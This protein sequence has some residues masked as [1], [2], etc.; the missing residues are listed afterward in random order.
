MPVDQNTY[1]LSMEVNLLC[2]K[3]IA[4]I[5]GITK[6]LHDVE[7]QV[8]KIGLAFTKSMEDQTTVLQ[9]SYGDTLSSMIGD[10]DAGIEMKIPTGDLAQQV[11]LMAGA[12]KLAR[13]REDAEIAVAAV[14]GQIHGLTKR[15]V[16][17]MEKEQAIVYDRIKAGKELGIE[18][19]YAIK[20]AKELQ[21]LL[22]Q[23]LPID[24]K[25]SEDKKK[26]LETDFERFDINRK[27]LKSFK[28]QQ[29]TLQGAGL[30]ALNVDLGEFARGG[31]RVGLIYT[32]MLKPLEKVVKAQEMFAGAVYRSMG[33]MQKL[34]RDVGMYRAQLGATS[35]EVTETIQ[36]LAQAGIAA[37]HMEQLTKS[38]VQFARV[39]GISN[40]EAAAFAGTMTKLTGKTAD[41]TIAMAELSVAMEQG[42]LTQ[43]DVSAV[44]NGMVENGAALNTIYGSGAIKGYARGMGKLAASARAAGVSV[45]VASGLMQKLTQDSLQYAALLGSAAV[46]KTPGENIELMASKWKSLKSQVAAL[47]PGVRAKVM[48]AYGISPEESALLEKYNGNWKKMKTEVE[49]NKK[50]QE[51]YQE[52]QESWMRTLVMLQEQIGGLVQALMSSFLPILKY[53]GKA[54]L[55]L[56]LPFALIIDLIK[57]LEK[58]SALGAAILETVLMASIV[59]FA[60]YWLGVI[61]KIAGGAKAVGNAFKNMGSLF[62]KAAPA[63][64]K[65][66]AAT[67]NMEKGISKSG[68][69]GLS[70]HRLGIGIKSFFR[71]MAKLNL[72]GVIK[73]AAAMLILGGT[74]WLLG[75]AFKFLPPTTLI[76]MGVAMIGFGVLIFAASKFLS[77]ASPG[78]ILFSVA[79]LLIAA[80]IFIVAAGTAILINAFTGLVEAV[81]GAEGLVSL[82]LGMI[83]LGVGMMFLG[84]GLGMLMMTVVPGIAA[85]TMFAV[86]SWFLQ[87]RLEA[88]GAAVAPVG[89]AMMKMAQSAM[90]MFKAAIGIY[91]L[92]D[93]MDSFDSGKVKAF[94]F[95]IGSLLSAIWAM[96]F[97]Q[98]P[99]AEF[100]GSVEALSAAQRGLDLSFLDKISSEDY[101]TKKIRDIAYSIYDLAFAISTLNVASSFARMFGL[102]TLERM[103]AAPKKTTQ[104]VK[105]EFPPAERR[106]NEGQLA[107]LKRIR[108]EIEKSNSHLGSMDKYAAERNNQLSDIVALLKDNEGGALGSG[109]PGANWQ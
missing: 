74:L 95:G 80:A 108:Q 106:A 11:E 43:E 70:L 83:M 101:N 73:F 77:G 62:S 82:G 35:K 26:L 37:D 93:A 36:A 78:L 88:F 66:A 51:S 5:M 91:V 34:T 2:G 10:I 107:E 14:Q 100:A 69:I 53:V 32:L 58:E 94:S 15:I 46:F 21:K 99:L 65:T 89:E 12:L 47:P 68:G 4:Q 61:P 17:E 90:G 67:S 19:T 87:G 44:M 104:T 42:K 52:T 56:A 33:N 57:M 98:K 64:Q 24:E 38:S 18:G 29:K 20:H 97:L 84:M 41:S 25:I 45:S 96:S 76:A 39:T 48:E 71:S 109:H 13:T 63:L 59:V 86:A 7:R 22:K 75:Y 28:D 27:L 3:S 92:A 16:T 72:V 6:M 50:L 79:L 8:V 85:L 103:T 105:H 54:L 30:K 81:G 55:I 49:A 1:S 23:I 31:L 102:D 60:G 40:Q 9:D